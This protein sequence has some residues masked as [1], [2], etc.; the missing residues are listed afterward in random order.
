MTE[1]WV[2]V[3][4]APPT[5]GVVAVVPL[6]GETDNQLQLAGV[7]IAVQPTGVLRALL[8]R[9]VFGAGGGA[10][11]WTTKSNARG[12]MTTSPDA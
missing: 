3:Q 4:I 11:G 9:S 12:E 8:M 10:P 6:A 5:G 7:T 1:S 2:V